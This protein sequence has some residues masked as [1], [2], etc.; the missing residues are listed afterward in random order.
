MCAKARALRECVHIA[1]AQHWHV[2]LAAP[3]IRGK[4]K[5]DKR[6]LLCRHIAT[7]AGHFQRCKSSTCT[8]WFSVSRGKLKVLDGNVETALRWLKTTTPHCRL[9]QVC[10]VLVYLC[11]L[12]IGIGYCCWCYRLNVS[13]FLLS[14]DFL[15]AFLCRRSCMT[16]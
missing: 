15:L 2:R 10:F 11:V 6:V 12:Y 16:A 7:L 3:A 1:P 5:L 14:L 9:N 4:H 8:T 13:L